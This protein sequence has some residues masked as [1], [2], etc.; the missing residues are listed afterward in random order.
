[1]PANTDRCT[2]TFRSYTSDVYDYEGKYVRIE[3]FN[4]EKDPAKEARPTVEVKTCEDPRFFECD[5]WDAARALFKRAAYDMDRTDDFY[6]VAVAARTFH[7]ADKPPVT[8]AIRLS[9][10]PHGQE[11]VFQRNYDQMERMGWTTT[12]TKN[13]YCSFHRRRC[14]KRFIDFADKGGGLSLDP[15][16]VPVTADGNNIIINTARE[17]HEAHARCAYIKA[18]IN[19]TEGDERKALRAELELFEALVLHWDRTR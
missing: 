9:A 13:H 6:L 18:L 2:S 19:E 16:V 1:M 4:W 15:W 3:L 5:N 10:L 7:E 12:W 11:F 8:G 14:D 17:R